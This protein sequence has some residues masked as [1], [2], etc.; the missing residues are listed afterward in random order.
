MDNTFYTKL[1]LFIIFLI[2]QVPI[3]S[4]TMTQPA[5]GDIVNIIAGRNST[6][7]CKTSE[8]LPASTILW[9]KDADANKSYGAFFGEARSSASNTSEGLFIVEST[10]TFSPAIEDHKKGIYCT[11]NNTNTSFVSSRQLLLNVLCK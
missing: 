8:G 2:F 1:L 6:F 9:F 10:L 5:R 11:A 4:V 3:S 7:R